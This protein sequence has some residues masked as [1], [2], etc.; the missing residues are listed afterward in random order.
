MNYLTYN[1]LNKI[2][3]TEDLDN[4]HIEALYDF[5]IKP[6]P[7]RDY[8]IDITKEDFQKLISNIHDILRFKINNQDFREVSTHYVK[9]LVADAMDNETVDINW[10]INHIYYLTVGLSNRLK[11]DKYK[12]CISF[13][14]Q[15]L[16]D[17]FNIEETLKEKVN[18]KIYTGIMTRY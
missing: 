6:Q 4:T 15:K 1:I 14:Q 5:Y 18:R 16:I 2:N 17:E 7:Y 3:K 12:D 9:L 10:A 8:K 13:V 11:T